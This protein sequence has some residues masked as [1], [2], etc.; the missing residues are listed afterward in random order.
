MER[1]TEQMRRIEHVIMALEKR[2]KRLTRALCFVLGL[3]LLTVIAAIFHPDPAKA[4]QVRTD[5]VKSDSVLRVRGLVVVDERGTE[6]VSI[7]T[8]DPLVLGKRVSRGEQFA[9]VLVFDA[10]G[11]ERGGYGTDDSGNVFLTLDEVG[12]MVGIFR[13]GRVG[14]VSL[15][16][17]GRG[18]QSSVSIGAMNT[19]SYLQ[20]GRQGKVYF[21]QPEAEKGKN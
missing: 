5:Q 20:L 17:T 6:R 11:N 14:G 3:L 1:E 8:T 9:G 13:A 21:Q 7:G 2:N 19:G 15:N 4:E 16:L 12:Q 18:D 10:E